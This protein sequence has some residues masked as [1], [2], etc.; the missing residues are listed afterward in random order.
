M[1]ESIN[2]LVSICHQNSVNAGWY[3]DPISGEPLKRNVPEMLMLIVSEVS[4]AMEGIRKNLIDDNLPYRKMGEV[5]LADALIRIC[6]LSGYLK[7]DLGGA[8]VEKI[9]YNKHRPDHKVENRVKEN[10]KQF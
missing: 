10:G 1:K 3:N 9:E 5:E 8:T 7:Y 2:E 4:E 6:D